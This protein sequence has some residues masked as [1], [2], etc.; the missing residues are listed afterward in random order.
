[1]IL[2]WF[3]FTWFFNFFVFIFILCTWK[4]WK[5]TLFSN[6]LVRILVLYLVLTTLQINWSP[7]KLVQNWGAHV[8]ST[9]SLACLPLSQNSSNKRKKKT[10]EK[11]QKTKNWVTLDPRLHFGSPN[12]ELSLKLFFFLSRPIEFSSKM[13]ACELNHNL[14]WF[15]LI[16]DPCL[17][18]LETNLK[19]LTNKN[20]Q[21]H[22]TQLLK[23]FSKVAI[24]KVMWNTHWRNISS[25]RAFPWV[26][27]AI[28][29]Y[30]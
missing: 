14:I 7:L 27:S 11:K 3:F 18:G 20:V 24:T 8:L 4:G 29:K 26:L 30:F 1:L 21:F 2:I 19:L 28:K 15:V 17:K 13:M 5:W 16:L 12:H 10:M 25:I 22:W 6:H 23:P 9:M